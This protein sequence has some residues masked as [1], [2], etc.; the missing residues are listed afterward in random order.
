MLCRIEQK[1]YDHA[2]KDLDSMMTRWKNFAKSYSLK[3]EVLLLQKDT[4]QG[5]KFLDKSLEIDPYD[6][7]LW[8]MRAMISL[9]R[10][11]WKDADAQLSKAIHLKPT[12]VDYYK[13]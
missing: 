10:K 9:S 1:D 3:A 5:A 12:T 8:A 4:V 13:H 6:G 11:K 2:N 7:N